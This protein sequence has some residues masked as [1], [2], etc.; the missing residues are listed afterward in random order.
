[1]FVSVARSRHQLL[2]ATDCFAAVSFLGQSRHFG[3][4]TTLSRRS[5]SGRSARATCSGGYTAGPDA[6]AHRALAQRGPILGARTSQ[7]AKSA[8]KGRASSRSKARCKSLRDA[9]G[10]HALGIAQ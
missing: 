8:S 1:M 3:K 9:A 6:Q 10:E 2:V 7:D 4:L 5:P